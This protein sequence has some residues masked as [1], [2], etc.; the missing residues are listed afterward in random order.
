MAKIWPEA[1]IERPPT[2]SMK[3]PILVSNVS[4]EAALPET[5]I[6]TVPIS[7]GAVTAGS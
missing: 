7:N 1:M 5:E 6:I 4:P 2:S 3:P